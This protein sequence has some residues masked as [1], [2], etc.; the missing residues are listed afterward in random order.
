M[1]RYLL[2]VVINTLCLSLA[3]QPS[4]PVFQSK[5]D[6]VKYATLQN[7][8]NSY[9]TPARNL[10]PRDQRT[11]DS[12]LT[13]HA[14]LRSR[15]IGYKTTYLK[16]P[17][18]IDYS[19]L[20]NGNTS[21]ER[22]VKLSYTKKSRK[23]PAVITR[24]TSLT[25]LEILNSSITKL[26][27]RLRKLKKLQTVYVYNNS[28]K[29]KLARNTTIT[30]LL[31]RGTEGRFIPTSFKKLTALDSLDLS[32]NIG[33]NRFPDVSRNKQLRKLLLI[34]NRITLTDL[35]ASKT[36]PALRELYLQRNA[37]GNVPATVGRFTGL[38]KLLFNYNPI[39]E[40][41][42]AIGQLKNLE[43]ISFYQNDLTEIPAGIFNLKNL[44]VIDLYFNQ[45][46]KIPPDLGNLTNLQILYLSNNRITSLPETIGQLKNLQEL[47]LHNNRLSYLPEQTKE[48]RQLQVLRIN[49][50]LFTTFPEPVLALTQ[51]ENL[52][53]S[54][55]TLR[56]FPLELQHFSKLKILVLINNH[57][58]N[59]A[60]MELVCKTLASQGTIIHQ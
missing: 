53:L 49:D 23:L 29:L 56:Q 7:L 33:L 10:E 46:E 44:R 15:I 38:Q 45:I 54:G 30:G 24:C 16:H 35:K 22:I 51:L 1:L 25:K 34:E 60:D 36:N 6:S 32:K 31:I 37:I 3:G 52:D 8:I 50:N 58:E 42:Q 43:E 27:A 18:F 47:Y 40:V 20:E 21:P 55:N 5:A 26:P 41:D 39:T 17:D 12:L 28:A 48:L 2:I 11:L 57:W 9:F 4:Y 19:E 13:K 59:P 14:E